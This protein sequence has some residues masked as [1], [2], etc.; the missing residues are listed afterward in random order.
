MGERTAQHGAEHVP[1]VNNPKLLLV[2]SLFLGSINDTNI[3]NTKDS[4]IKLN[5]EKGN[6]IL[7]IHNGADVLFI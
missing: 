7:K 3:K 2:N 4:K 5:T 1:Y 6:I